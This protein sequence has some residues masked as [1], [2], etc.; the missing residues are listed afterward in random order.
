MNIIPYHSS[1]QQY[2]YEKIGACVP[3]LIVHDFFDR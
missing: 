3:T 2:E 1:G